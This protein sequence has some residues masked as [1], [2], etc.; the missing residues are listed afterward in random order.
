MSIPKRLAKKIEAFLSERRRS[1]HG[2]WADI[3][4]DDITDLWKIV[5]MLIAHKCQP[6][7][8][9]GYPI[10]VQLVNRQTHEAMH[11]VPVRYLHKA[12]SNQEVLEIL[13]RRLMN[14]SLATKSIDP[15]MYAI[16]ERAILTEKESP[17]AR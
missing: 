17:D 15:T 14:L 13:N 16:Q 9:G 7:M 3:S 11:Y 2:E 1:E 12:K 6:D 10:Q 8:E 5:N 4:N